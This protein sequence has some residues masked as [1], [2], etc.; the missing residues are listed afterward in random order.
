MKLKSK[1]W[2]LQGGSAAWIHRKGADLESE[3]PTG[4]HREDGEAAIASRNPRRV[5]PGQRD[6]PQLRAVKTESLADP[7]YLVTAS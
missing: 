3:N 6:V 1:R 7:T 2:L 4:L 5:D